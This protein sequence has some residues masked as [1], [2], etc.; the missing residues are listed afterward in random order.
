MP[1]LYPR[2]DEMGG[3]IR[4]GLGRRNDGSVAM[5]PPSI[6][7][8]PLFRASD[9]EV[10]NHLCEE[11]TRLVGGTSWNEAALRIELQSQDAGTIS[12]R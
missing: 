8:A 11:S 4:D 1:S 9:A 6:D 7:P 5:T 3:L 12:N 2:V 10:R